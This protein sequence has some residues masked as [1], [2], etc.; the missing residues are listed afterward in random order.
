MSFTHSAMCRMRAAMGCLRR[1]NALPAVCQLH[2][3]YSIAAV[4]ASEAKQSGSC[5]PDGGDCFV[6]LRALAMTADSLFRLQ[7]GALHDL[8]PFLD[9]TCDL[10]ARLGRGEDQRYR[11]DIGVAC[12][13]SGILETCVD[14]PIEALDDLGGRRCWGAKA[15]PG[16]EFE[17][18]NDFADRGHPR[19]RR[20]SL[21][22][23]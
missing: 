19:N 18:W 4:I 23:H 13:Q 15:C 14:I 1:C 10:G 11:A 9:V 6:A 12:L 22:R 7:A 20:I 8:A 3:T 5:P 17:A 21:R 2:G 16:A